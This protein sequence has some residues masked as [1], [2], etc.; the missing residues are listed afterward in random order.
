MTNRKSHTRFR[1]VAKSTTLDDLECPLRTL[2]QNTCI[3]GAQHTNLNENRPKRSAVKMWRNDS[4]FWKYHVYADIRGDSLD[5]QLWDVKRH[6]A[7]RQRQ[8]SVLSVAVSSET[9][10]IRPV[11]RPLSIDPKTHDP[12]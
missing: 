1:F 4:S 8:F 5:V 9:L 12:E 2:F 11:A 7:C 6:W 10:E 3:F